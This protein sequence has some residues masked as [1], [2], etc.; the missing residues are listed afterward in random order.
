MVVAV[1]E[2]APGK[3]ESHVAEDPAILHLPPRGSSVIFYD[4]VCALC[5]GFVRLVRRRDPQ[6]RYYFAS[7]QGE[8][9]HQSLSRHGC[10]PDDLDTVYLLLRYGQSEESVLRGTQAALRILR[11]LGGFWRLVS[12]LDVLPRAVLDFG[13]RL[14]VRSRYRVFGKYTSCPLPAP[15]ESHLFIHS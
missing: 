4:G 13:Y 2:R 8:F 3:E 6:E 10:N 9:A 11:S 15:E 12:L 14:V 1:R 7:L 5:N